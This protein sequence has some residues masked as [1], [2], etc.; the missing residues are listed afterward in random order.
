VEFDAETINAKCKG[1]SGEPMTPTEVTA[2]EKIRELV[3]RI[4]PSRFLRCD[5]PPATSAT[6]PRPKFRSQI[7][8]SKKPSKT[9]RFQG[10]AVWLRGQD[11][12]S[13]PSGYEG[14]FFAPNALI[15]MHFFSSICQ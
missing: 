4:A 11:L 14:D 8:N 9:K 15:D 3:P 7:G 12:N 10:L 13:R 1:V 6:L 2:W 5:F